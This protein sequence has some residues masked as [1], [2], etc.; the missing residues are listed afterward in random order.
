MRSKLFLSIATALAGLLAPAQAGENKF[1]WIEGE[2]AKT[3]TVTRHPWWYEKV[4]KGELS[5]GDFI[6]NWG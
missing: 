6:A 5:G 1:V 2:A 4:K 3:K